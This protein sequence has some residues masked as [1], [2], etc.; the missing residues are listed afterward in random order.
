MWGGGHFFLM[1][2]LW[3]YNNYEKIKLLEARNEATSL[4]YYFLY[5]LM[6]ILALKISISRPLK[7]FYSGAIF[8]YIIPLI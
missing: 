8:I 1:G 2:F 6:V 7:R 3:G 4:I 5:S